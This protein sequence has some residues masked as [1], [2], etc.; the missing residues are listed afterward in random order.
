MSCSDAKLK[1]NQRKKFPS[2]ATIYIGLY[3]KLRIA[4]AIVTSRLVVITSISL[5]PQ[6]YL[7]HIELDLKSKSLINAN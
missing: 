4:I 3:L 7:L 2:E 5:I 1:D 6:L